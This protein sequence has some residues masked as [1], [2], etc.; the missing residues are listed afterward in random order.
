MTNGGGQQ[1]S[2]EVIDATNEPLDPE[3]KVEP[4]LEP[5][6]PAEDR[7][8]ARRRLAYGLLFLLS[9]IAIS[10]LGAA[11]ADWITNDE[12]KNLAQAILAPVV[13]LTGTALGFYFG[14]KN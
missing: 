13:V 11:Y 4:R 8:T 10:L 9:V 12:A 2:P 1:P 7:E 6:D 5:Y 3:S 14:G